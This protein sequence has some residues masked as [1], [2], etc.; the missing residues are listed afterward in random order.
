MH[1]VELLKLCYY[2]RDRGS[3][4]G[5]RLD[6]CRGESPSI[7]LH[8]GEVVNLSPSPGTSVCNG[9]ETLSCLYNRIYRQLF[10]KEGPSTLQQGEKHSRNSLCATFLE[11]I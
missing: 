6:W 10:V 1:G 7:E 11:S 5:A 8:F 4:P 2:P 9:V 3:H